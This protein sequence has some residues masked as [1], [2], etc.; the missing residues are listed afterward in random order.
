MVVTQI[1]DSNSNK[2]EYIFS[3]FYLGY[4]PLVTVATIHRRRNL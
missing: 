4:L 1:M 3:T 2:F